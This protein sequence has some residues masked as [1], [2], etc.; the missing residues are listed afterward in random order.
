VVAH[1][2]RPPISRNLS[3]DVSILFIGKKKERKEKNYFKRKKTRVRMEAGYWL[4]F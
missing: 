1:R 3:S 2:E 4:P